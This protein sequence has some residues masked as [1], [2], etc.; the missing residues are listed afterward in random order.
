VSPD[1]RQ[2]GSFSW[3]PIAGRPRSAAQGGRPRAQAFPQ[4]AQDLSSENFP[5]AQQNYVNIRQAIRKQGSQ[6]QGPPHRHHHGEGRAQPPVEPVGTGTAIGRPRPPRRLRARDSTSRRL[7]RA[8]RSPPRPQLR[9]QTRA[10]TTLRINPCQP[11]Q[12]RQEHGNSRGRDRQ[13][14]MML[15]P[16]NSGLPA[17]AK[18][19][20]AN[21]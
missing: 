5:A 2:L 10:Q 21:S 11:D 18:F 13:R 9:A 16:C 1:R 7:V 20:S 12:A 8:G 6:T 15:P 3:T 19:P 4:L 14:V 17:A